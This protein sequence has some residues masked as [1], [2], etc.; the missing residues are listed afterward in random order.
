MDQNKKNK[1][2]DFFRKEGF[3]LVLLVCLC[4]VATVAAFTIKKNSVAKEQNNTSNELSLNDVQDSNSSEVDS[5]FNMQNAERVENNDELAE[6]NDNEISQE[7]VTNEVDNDTNDTNE[8]IVSE[9][10]NNSE[11]EADVDVSAGTDSNIVLSLPID[12]EVAISREFGKMVR[13]YSDETRS[14]DTS[15]R[16][17]DIN[18]AVGT[19]VKA[20]AEG[21][22]EEVSSNTTDGTYVVIAHA[23]G[24]KTKYANLSEDVK[25]A[26]GDTVSAGTE[27]GTVG[28]SSG[29]FTS[30]ICGDV[31]NV[32]VQDAN[33]KDVDP[34]AYFEMK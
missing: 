24:L 23:N 9:N 7:E 22:V 31:L 2:K 1:V 16:G 15:R 34:S 18:A 33:G 11:Q 30:K 6:A 17:I 10:Q 32:Q 4:V 5:N 8:A 27:I 14:E 29:I 26:A 20:A 25:V 21:K 19:T 12:G 3:Y 28:N 13:T